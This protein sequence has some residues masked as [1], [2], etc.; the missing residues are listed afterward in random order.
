[1][2]HPLS[3]ANFGTLLRV[4]QDGGGADQTLKIMGILG[5]VLARAP[6]SLAE[7]LWVKLPAP[8]VDGP[9]LFVLGHWR[10]GTTHL[11]NL[12]AAGGWGYVPPVPVGLPHDV[13]LLARW[14]RPFLERQ[15]P[16]T[17]WIDAIPVTP[18]APQEDEIALASM[19]PLSFY[20]GLYFPRAFD[21]LVD[22]GV[23]FDGATE[24]EIADWQAQLR[25]FLSRIAH[26]QGRRLAIKNPT[27]TARPAMLRAMFPGAKFIHLHRDP[28]DVFLSMR[29]FHRRLLDVMALQPVPSD[30]DIDATILRVYDRMMQRFTEETAGWG[31]P[32]FVE[33]A[34]ADLD[35]CPL[36]TLSKIYGTLELKGLDVALPAF[37]QHLESVKQYSRNR[38]EPEPALAARLDTAWGRWFDRFGYP[39][40]GNA[41][42]GPAMTPGAATET[43]AQNEGQAD[44]PMLAAG[45]GV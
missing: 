16:E 43:V 18:T 5:A 26:H 24:A 45:E 7:R 1:M 41:E 2:A 21:R 14:L 15:L 31:A 28:L 11:Y 4:V 17:R 20:H 29:N 39:R 10:S 33:I 13:H 40:P 37:E 35:A 34:Y 36:D 27:Y 19:S 42:I 32:D 22:R 3:G 8:D 12:L 44:V 6:F 9:P 38:F 30:L 23:F 25:L